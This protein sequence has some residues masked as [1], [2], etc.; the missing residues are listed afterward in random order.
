MGASK[1]K[2]RVTYDFDSEIPPNIRAEIRRCV[3]AF[4]PDWL[5]ELDVDTEAE[6]NTLAQILVRDEYHKAYLSIGELLL[7]A[8][9]EKVRLTILH[10]IAHLFTTPAAYPGRNYILNH[11]ESPERNTLDTAANKA[12]E[13]ATECLARVFARYSNGS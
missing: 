1:P 5:R 13:T 11:P 2:G 3:V 9:P 8:S 7:T 12:V 6:E 4:A 10:E